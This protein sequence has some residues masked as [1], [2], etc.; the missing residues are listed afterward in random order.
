MWIQPFLALL[1]PVILERGFFGEP[2]QAVRLDHSGIGLAVQLAGAENAKGSIK[3]TYRYPQNYFLVEAG[4]YRRLR[5]AASRMQR[6]SMP[7]KTLMLLKLEA[8]PE[9]AL[10][11]L[12]ADVAVWLAEEER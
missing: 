6:F 11:G 2:V 5:L 12:V 3:I 4:L 1:G 8:K 9:A 7:R 10:S